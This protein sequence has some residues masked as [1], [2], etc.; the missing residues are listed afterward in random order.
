MKQLLIAF[1]GSCIAMPVLYAQEMVTVTGKITVED[2][3]KPPVGIITLNEKG[4]ADYLVFGDNIGTNRHTFMEK[5]G[6]FKFAVQ[7]G[8]TV[9]IKVSGGRYL[10]PKPVA[11]ISE[12]TRL[13]LQLKR[14][15]KSSKSD[16]ADKFEIDFNPYK[17]VKVTGRVLDNNNKPIGSA[18]VYQRSINENGANAH[19]V[20]D[21]N[22][23]FSYVVPQG[24]HIS[25]GSMGFEYKHIKVVKDTALTVILESKI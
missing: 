5:D 7:K 17:R 24:S 19:T 21:K 23:E 1:L 14:N 18:T 22:G 15:P 10:N 3:G 6:T 8:G 13:E 12:D 11:N 2:T 4:V 20:T 25:F 16:E 9:V